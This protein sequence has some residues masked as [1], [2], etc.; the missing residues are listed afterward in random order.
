MT[1]DYTKISNP[2]ASRPIVNL[3]GVMY[4]PF[5]TLIFLLIT[6]VKSMFENPDEITATSGG[7]AASILVRN[8]EV[9]T[10][11]DSDEDNVTLANGLSGQIKRIYC[12]AVGN[13]ADSFKITP[14]NMVGG[15]KIT[16]AANPLGLGCILAYA[17]N[18]G[19]VV[20]ANNGGT[21]A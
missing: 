5:R 14:A 7:V 20:V 11:G 3:S 18:E 6:A 8:T 16:F 19:W 12:V 1:I 21:I 10:N 15:T 13:A 17:D 9:T 2:D 4:E